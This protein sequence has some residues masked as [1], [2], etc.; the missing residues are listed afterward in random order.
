MSEIIRDIAHHLLE[1][2]LELLEDNATILS[3]ELPT[4]FNDQKNLLVSEKKQSIGAHIK[5]SHKTIVTDGLFILETRMT[6]GIPTRGILKIKGP[7]IKITFSS[8]L[9]CSANESEAFCQHIFL[10]GKI[11]IVSGT[12]THFDVHCEGN[13]D[14]YMIHIL[15]SRAYYLELSK[16]EILNHNFSLF[17]KVKNNLDFYK[18]SSIHANSPIKTVLHKIVDN[19][20]IGSLKRHYVDSKIKGVLSLLLEQEMQQLPALHQVHDENIAKLYQAR[21][22]L[23]INYHD[24]P[25]IKTLSKLVGLNELKLKQGFKNLFG[26]TIHNYLTK[27][28][29]QKAYKFLHEKNVLIIDI[30]M[31]LGYKDTSHFIKTFKR[32]Y[33]YTPKH[34]SQ[35]LLSI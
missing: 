24:A 7:H 16:N 19:P 12:Q 14:T 8:E 27:I 20:F 32:Y 31:Q 4:E 34:F 1:V 21:D 13:M 22:I 35:K 5:I 9:P 29:M 10:N 11:Q 28:R 17:S 30:A 6:A 18:Q 26:T 23:T 25:T 2:E 3:V 15:M 33:G